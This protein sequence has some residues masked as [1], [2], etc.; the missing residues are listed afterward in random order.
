MLVHRVIS[1]IKGFLEGTP[2]VWEFTA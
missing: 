2:S 1:Q